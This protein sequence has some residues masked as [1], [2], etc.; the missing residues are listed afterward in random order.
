MVGRVVADSEWMLIGLIIG[1]PLGICIGWILSQLLKPQKAQASV[2][3]NRDSEG[4][5]TEI[6][7]VPVEQK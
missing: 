5:I 7:Y 4:R 3:F 2:V 6:H 1:V